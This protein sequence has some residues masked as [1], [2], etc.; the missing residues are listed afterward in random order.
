MTETKF[1]AEKLR[2]LKVFLIDS[3]IK[4]REERPILKLGKED[5][6]HTENNVTVGVNTKKKELRVLYDLK[7]RP[8]IAGEF[9]KAIFAKFVF[10]FYFSL[11]NFDDLVEQT[12]KEVIIDGHLNVNLSAIAYST[13]RG[14]IFTRFQDTYLEGAYLP[15]IDPVKLI[16]LPLMNKPA[17][18]KKLVKKK[19]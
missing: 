7:I 19:A 9:D 14:L 6:I 12:E 1:R 13:L 3:H 11:E 17:K 4:N 15:I 10:H 5:T 16:R 8:K 18:R 2:L